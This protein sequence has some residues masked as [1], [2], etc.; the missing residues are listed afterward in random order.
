MNDDEI[1]ND[2]AMEI[3]LQAI[4]EAIIA[5][6]QA[7]T[8]ISK[9]ET[10]E[11]STRLSLIICKSVTA[12]IYGAVLGKITAP[13]DSKIREKVLDALADAASVIDGLI[14]GLGNPETMR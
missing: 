4:G 9:I 3:A 12:W 6:E 11:R 7:F 13:L 2:K 8:E 5:A 14:I 1:T 10:S